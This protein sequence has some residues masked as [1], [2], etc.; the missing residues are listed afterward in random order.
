MQWTFRTVVGEQATGADAAQTNIPAAAPKPWKLGLFA[1]CNYPVVCL[2]VVFCEACALGQIW[3]IASGGNRMMCQLVTA[4]VLVLLVAGAI[5]SLVSNTA[6]MTIGSLLSAMAGALALF[7]V[8]FAR[9][10]V[11]E[12]EGIRGSGLGDCCATFWCMP[13]AMAQILNEYPPFKNFFYAYDPLRSEDDG[14]VA[15]EGATEATEAL[16][17]V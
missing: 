15:K 8:C 14:T 12:R 1:C 16:V 6:T 13:L 7:V 9:M 4:V 5:F 11:R 10:R 3:S 2:N 17:A